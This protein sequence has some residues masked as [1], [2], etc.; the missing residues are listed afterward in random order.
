MNPLSPGHHVI[1]VDGIPQEYEVRGQGPA[2]CLALS[3][4]PGID[5][6]YLRFPLLEEDITMVYPTQVGTTAESRLPSHPDGYTLDVYARFTHAVVEHL[7]LSR[8]H[9]LGHSAGGFF[10]QRYALTY[11]ERLA[12]LVIYDSL[13]HNTEELVKEATARL[14]EFADRFPGDPRVAPVLA[15]WTD[16]TI[17]D[18][19]EARTEHLRALLPAYFADY[20]GR[21][22]EFARLAGL[23]VTH[24][25]GG[26]FDHRGRLDTVMTPT[27]VVV[28]AYDFI[29]GPRWARAMDDELPNSTVVT[30]KTSGHFGHIEQP[31]EFAAAV[32]GFVRSVKNGGRR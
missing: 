7:G 18:T 8:V 13:A 24:V 9:L 23:R 20:W 12:G 26:A 2:V 1:E 6:G 5:D 3:G 32:L 11:P 29:C 15:A 16:D 19:D 27:L 28:G 4:G 14:A 10:A 21:E 17:A 22:E 25:T 30:L 31:E